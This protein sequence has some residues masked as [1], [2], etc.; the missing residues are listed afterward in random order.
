MKYGIWN[1]AVPDAS[2]V[3]LLE[4]AGYSPLS[5]RVLCSRGYETP[6]A[7]ANYLDCNCPL[8]DPLEM[9]DMDRAVAAIEA[10]L[11]KKQRIAVFGDYDVDGITASCLMAQY[12]RGRGAHCVVHIPGRLAEGYGLNAP[13]IEQLYADG[14]EMIITVD[15]GITAM[16]EAA[17]CKRLGI[18]LVITDH[19]EC[20]QTLPDAVAVVD[21]HRPDCTYPHKNLAGVGVAFALV[22]ALSGDSDW[23][24]A[25]F[26]DLVCLGSIADVMPLCGQTRRLVTLGLAAMQAPQR[27]GLRALIRESGCDSRSITAA[28]VGYVLAPR[29]NAAGRMECA[30]LAVR[31]FLTDDAQEAGELAKTLCALNTQRQQIEAEIYREATAALGN[32][33]SLGGAIVLAAEHWHQ[34]VVGIV[35]SR[36]SEEFCRPTF[37]I[38]LDG[39]HGKA[40][41]RSFGGFNLFAALAELSPLL[42]GYGGHEQAAGFTI[43]R[44][45][46]DAFR[47]AV[48]EKAAAFYSAGGA[49]SAL[50]VDCE[51]DPALLT[52]EN[53][54]ALAQL[55]PCGTGCVK[56]LFCIS[57]MQI[58]RVCTVGSGK[59]LRLQLTAKSGLS[60]QAIYF[61]AGDLLR[62]LSVGD[63]ID[64]V[65]SPQMNSFRGADT[66]QLFLSDLRAVRPTAFYERFRANKPLS[67]AEAL[68]LS[69]E[70]AD[71]AHV[72]NYLRVSA[73]LR[74]SIDEL[75]HAVSA[76]SR[77]RHSVRRTLPCLDV[78]AELALIALRRTGAEIEIEIL[79]HSQKNP[80]ENSGLFQ[81]L[82]SLKAGE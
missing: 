15:C 14:V 3:A 61:S 36:L 65:F 12:L 2:A 19:H 81:T 63:C 6:E 27:P 35:A 80:L 68:L 39:E 76:H 57:E 74:C 52:E 42:E 16:E 1:V 82:C 13:A 33:E 79:P 31:L 28:T 20:K 40:S 56:P 71:V 69:P 46:L 54:R 75:C 72:W 60:F 53:I 37:L 22:C 24:M 38:C 5:A 8:V 47:Q 58:A 77:Y 9:K 49:Q 64:A 55:E 44:S 17:L 4:K 50:E 73:P 7:A 45:N 32:P 30:E 25:Q 23:A 21:P 51:I 18:T 78:L 10:A 59:H 29:I 67:R 62:N 70:R 48:S 41:S 66:V 34:G 11:E 26:C 43:A